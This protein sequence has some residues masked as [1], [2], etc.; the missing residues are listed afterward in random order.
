[1]VLIIMTL[2]IISG[3]FIFKRDSILLL[4]SFF[5]SSQNFFQATSKSFSVKSS[6]GSSTS[7]SPLSSS[8]DFLKLRLA[9]DNDEISF[10]LGCLNN[11]SE[12]LSSISKISFS[13]LLFNS[14]VLIKDFFFVNYLKTLISLNKAQYAS[15]YHLLFDN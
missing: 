7:T 10:I 5:S 4:P 12:S 3:W 8:T 15:V 14:V 11:L 9:I 2:S 1:M 6:F 13:I